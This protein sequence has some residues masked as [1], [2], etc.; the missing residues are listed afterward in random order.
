MTLVLCDQHEGAVGGEAAGKVGKAP[1]LV[2]EALR[3]LR[4]EQVE[5]LGQLLE[6]GDWPDRVAHRWFV[7]HGAEPV[8]AI[9]SGCLRLSWA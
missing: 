4:A 6:G 1:V 8:H 3:E 5:R 2:G 7:A 9:S